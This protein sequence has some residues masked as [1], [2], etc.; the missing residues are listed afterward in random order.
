MP[1]GREGRAVVATVNLID[2]VALFRRLPLPAQARHLIDPKEEA[3]LRFDIESVLQFESE[4]SASLGAGPDAAPIDEAQM[5]R[6][7]ARQLQ[8]ILQLTPLTALTNAFNAAILGLLYGRTSIAPF[9]GLWT[10]ALLVVV[11]MGV[12]AWWRSRRGRAPK[13]VSQRAERRAVGHAVALALLWALVPAVVLP[14]SDSWEQGLVG[15]ITVGMI[16]AGGFALASIPAAGCSFPLIVGVGGVIGV[17]RTDLPGPGLVTV[18]L[19]I[20]VSVVVMSVRSTAASFR[21]RL[22]AEAAA[23]RQRD[24]VGLLL[25]DFEAHTSDA[26]WEADERGQL[27]HASPRLADMLGRTPGDLVGR[28]LTD[29]FESNTDNSL[30]WTALD[31]TMTAESLSLAMAMGQP[32]HGLVVPFRS[33]VDEGGWVQLAATPLTDAGGRLQGWRGVASN[34]TRE[35]EAAQRVTLLAF[36]DAVTGL[37]NRHS[38][39]IRLGQM[40]ANEAP[41][42]VM[43]MDLDGFKTVNDALGH[44][45]GD[46]LLKGVAQR[47]SEVLR[48]QDLLARIGGDEFGLIFD[49]IQSA[50]DAAQIAARILASLRVPCEVGG[51]TV[52][53][54]ASLGVVLMPRD[55]RESDVIMKHADLALYAAKEAGRGQYRFFLPQMGA[56]VLR[57]LSIE[58]AL[59]DALKNDE[60]S[61]D[62]QPQLD[63]ATADIIGF[64]ALLRWHHP[65]LGQVSPADFVPVAEDAGLIGDI[66]RWVVERACKQAR[67]WPDNLRVAVNL[68]PLQIMAQDLHG[69]ICTALMQSGLAPQ[70]LE[71]EVTESVLLNETQ[72]TL[73]QLHGIRELGGRIALDDFGTGYSSMAYLR[74]FPF[75]KLKIDRSFVREMVA[76][77]DARAIVQAM[78]D[79]ASALRMDTVA[80]GVETLAEL[81]ALHDMGC[82]VIQGYFV[83]RPM[84]GAAVEAFLQGWGQHPTR[85]AL[86][87]FNEDLVILG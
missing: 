5:G 30:D 78:L 59:R 44:A 20:Y 56:K 6:F 51:A 49:G 79:M 11:A 87:R 70:R 8:T 73:S 17:W 68:S 14:A 63:L 23:E 46:E 45:I 22:L 27:L 28:R 39:Q 48:P 13:S 77:K 1:D 85:R 19:G 9:V 50:D 64:E 24:L 32:F 33:A 18:M 7:R 34:V 75:D 21:A 69:V 16:C 76:G 38:F 65:D 26:L 66:G 57:R 31:L 58:R 67:N 37:H 83:A 4:P 71:F 61:L 35:R 74:R 41:C 47:V 25:H 86:Q 15:C 62:F 72:A 52:P 12:R 29:L 54:G 82:K 3:S 43:C 53:I 80:E 40:V 10:L 2:P 42:V 81:Q 36:K 60:L 84:P 55:G